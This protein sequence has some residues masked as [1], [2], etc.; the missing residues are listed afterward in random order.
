MEIKIC[1]GPTFLLYKADDMLFMCIILAS[2]GHELRPIGLNT[3]TLT[4]K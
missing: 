3:G 4:D 1:I 2:F